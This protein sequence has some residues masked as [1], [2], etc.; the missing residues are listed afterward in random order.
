M[1]SSLGYKIC[2]HLIYR[3]RTKNLKLSFNAYTIFDT[4]GIE[5]LLINIWRQEFKFDTTVTI[6]T[7]LSCVNQRALRPW[8][9]ASSLQ[10]VL[11]A[12]HTVCNR[13]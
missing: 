12:T 7:A 13:Q 5:I 1:V 8:T 4:F 9:W 10:T 3:N 11:S 6:E 2:I